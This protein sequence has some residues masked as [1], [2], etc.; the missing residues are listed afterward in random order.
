MGCAP[1]RPVRKRGPRSPRLRFV[2]HPMRL[3]CVPVRVSSNTINNFL[4]LLS[5]REAMPP[6][7]LLSHPNS[8]CPTA[9]PGSCSTT[10]R[11][12]PAAKQD[13]LRFWPDPPEDIQTWD[14]DRSSCLR[15]F[16][17][18]PCRSPLLSL[19]SPRPLPLPAGTRGH[20]SLAVGFFLSGK[21][22]RRI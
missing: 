9:C 14:R 15:T 2:S 20:I 17:L 13:R 11:L 16:P 7:L 18:P 5:L 19:Q 22:A 6:V 3:T 8:P 4:H 21:R 10:P 1:V 12:L